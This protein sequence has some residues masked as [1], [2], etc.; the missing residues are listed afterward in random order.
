MIEKL[1]AMG[2]SIDKHLSKGNFLKV[3][4]MLLKP[5]SM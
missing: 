3:M 5:F 1:V 2:A 4:R